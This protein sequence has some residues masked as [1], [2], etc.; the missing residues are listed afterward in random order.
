MST[1]NLVTAM[2]L[3]ACEALER[4]DRLPRQFF[5]LGRGGQAYAWEPPIDIF[6]SERGLLIH[7]A[8]PDAQGTDFKVELGS[9]VLRLSGRRAM[10]DAA[11]RSVIHRLE[12]PFGRIER[13]IALPA[14]QFELSEIG[15]AD[16]C[17]HI[18]LIRID[19]SE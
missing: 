2:W 3:Q 16:G 5:R 8:V 12:I 13:V 15:Y 18:R 7:V 1:P 14:G 6:E 19:Q 9:R 11:R 10:P 17:L 4:A